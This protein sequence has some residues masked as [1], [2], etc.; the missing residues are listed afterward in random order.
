M[1][2]KIIAGNLAVVILLGVASYVMISGQLRSELGGRLDS[3]LSNQKTL[4]ERSYKL[5]AEEFKELVSERASMD[6]LRAVFSGLDETSRRTRAY[7]AAEAT[8]AWLADPA[9]G[10]RGAPDI[11]VITDE[12]GRALARNGARNVMFGKNLLP[13]IPALSRALKSGRAE[14]DVW[15]EKQENKV[16]QTAVAPITGTTGNTLGALIVGYD[17]SNGVAQREGQLLGREVAFVANGRL[18]SSSL[19]GAAARALGAALFEQL[20][21]ETESVLEGRASASPLWNVSIDGEAYTGVTARLPM[22]PSLPV[23]FVVMGNRTEAAA[24]ADAANVALILMLLAVVMVSGYGFV[25]GTSIV[26]PIEEIEEGV[27]AIINGR[28]DLRLET[29]SPELGGLAYRINQLLNV[30]TGTEE[31]SGDGDDM[32][33][34]SRAS[35]WDAGELAEGGASRPAAAATPRP[36]SPSGEDVVDD[37]EVAAVLAAEAEADYGARLY[38][39]Y[40]QAKE[41]LGEN[42][43]NIPQERFMQ[44]VN[45]RADA[46]AKKHGCRAVRFQVHTRDSQVVLRPVLIR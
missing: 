34:Q 28:T 20:K 30:F 17:L 43:S 4:L 13:N 23:A 3:G 19:P 39:E 8:Q 9:R 35:T 32:P 18:Y 6:Q 12:T 36:A 26:R 33:V 45:G 46:L 37:P 31:D 14:H 38:Q 16:L 5:S 21:P 29:D 41:A 1:R 40:V 27:L 44:R 25:V 7:E 22:S 15:L 2:L 10:G 24:P 11:V 42:V